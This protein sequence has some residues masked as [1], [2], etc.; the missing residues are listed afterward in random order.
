MMEP[1]C[2]LEMLGTDY[3]VAWHLIPEEREPQLHQC[4]NLKTCKFS[5]SLQFVKESVFYHDNDNWLSR[6][7]NLHVSEPVMLGFYCVF[8]LFFS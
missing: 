1:L 7:S 2:S 3:P 6:R 5:L 4:K 8:R